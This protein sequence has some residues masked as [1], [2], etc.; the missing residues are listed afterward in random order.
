MRR[1]A[2]K[3]SDIDCVECGQPMSLIQQP[4]AD[5]G[6]IPLITC[7]QKSCL[8]YGVTLSINQYH[9]LTEEDLEAYRE[10]NRV[11]RAK[12]VKRDNG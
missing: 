5:G 12:F 2:A 9:R 4:N 3:N 8:M 10:M 11:S 1:D 6:Y 7:W